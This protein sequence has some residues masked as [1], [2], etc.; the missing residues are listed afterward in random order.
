MFGNN[1]SFKVDARMV[2]E[3]EPIKNYDVKKTKEYDK[4]DEQMK[5]GSSNENE[6]V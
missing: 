2:R 3:L 1:Y 6:E 4:V 5:G